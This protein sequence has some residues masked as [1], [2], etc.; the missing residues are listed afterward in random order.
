MTTRLRIP[1]ALAFTLCAFPASAT[2]EPYWITYEGNDFPE[3]EG[4]ERVFCDPNGVVG[5]GGAIRTIEDGAL[6]LDSR[7]STRIVDF[8]DWSCPIDPGSGETFVMRWR[9]LV[10]E[11]PSTYPYDLTVGVFSDQFSAVFFA[12]GVNEMKSIFEP[13]LQVQYEAHV[14]HTFELQSLD[15]VSYSLWIDDE[16]SLTGQFESVFQASR[17]SWGDGAQGASSLS[18]WDFLEFGVVP[19]P[20]TSYLLLLAACVL[21]NQKINGDRK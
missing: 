9:L 19:E 4:W 8:Y 21:A 10:D 3:N 14:F 15:M 18:H 7:E 11:V 16:L 5:Q 12:L 17:V 2:A 13:E 6:V 20:S 1:L